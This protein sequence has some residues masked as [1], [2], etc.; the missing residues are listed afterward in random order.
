MKRMIMSLAVSV[1]AATACFATDGNLE[2]WNAGSTVKLAD[3]EEYGIGRCFAATEIP[4]KVFARMKG[5]TF[6][7]N[8]TIPR[9]ELRYVKVLHYN[10]EKQVRIGELVCNKAIAADLVYI[11]RRLFDAKYPIGRMVL[12]DDYGADDIRSMEA[13]NT[14]CFNFR[15]VSG[16]KVLSNHS[17]GMAIDINPLYNPYVVKRKDGTLFVSPEKGRRYAARKNKFAFKIDKSDLCYRLFTSR[18][19][20][21]G[22]DWKKKKDYQHFEKR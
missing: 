14:S 22:G 17:R 13:N 8:C 12:I 18:G 21:W 10:L 2:N 20:V 7:D 16:T 9:G 4:E 19:F 11:F 6:K 5:K 1:F 15:F 3:V